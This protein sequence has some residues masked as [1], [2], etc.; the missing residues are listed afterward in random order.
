MKFILNEFLSV[1]FVL[2]LIASLFSVASIASVA[3]AVPDVIYVPEDYVTIQA[4][5]NA[6][7]SGDTIIVRDGTYVEN[8]VVA[9][10]LMIRSENGTDYTIIR[11]PSSKGP[12]F[13]VTS[14]YVNISGFTVRDATRGSN[15]G[16]YVE[17]SVGCI[18]SDNSA[19]N[20]YVG[21]Y[22]VSSKNNALINNSAQNNNMGIYLRSSKN[23]TLVNNNAKNGNRGI[24]LSSSKNNT[25]ISNNVSANDYGLY[26]RYSGGNLIYNNYF[27]NQ[28]NAYDNTNNIW[29][30]KKTP[31]INI[32]GGPNLG[33]NYWSDYMGIDYDGDGLG[34]TL[35]PHSS[36]GGMVNGGDF[37]PLVKVSEPPAITSWSPDS[38]IVNDVEGAKRTFGITLDQVA[39]VRWLVDGTQIGPINESVEEAAF[40][41]TSTEIGIKNVSAIVSNVNGVGMH[42]WAWNITE[43]TVQPVISK[44]TPP[45]NS[46]VNNN[47]TIIGANYSDG[48]G[49]NELLVTLYVDKKDVT[50]DAN[51]TSSYVAY[52]PMD[53]LEDGP[54]NATLN[55]VDSSSNQNYNTTAWNFSVDTILPQTRITSAP[56]QTINHND[57]VFKWTGSD[58]TTPTSKLLYSYKLGNSWSDWTTDEE[59]SFN[60]LSNSDYTFKVKAKDLAGNED[61]TPAEVSFKVS[62]SSSSSFA[63]GGGG[64]GG[65]IHPSQIKTNSRGKVLFTYTE[66]SPDSKAKIIIQKGTIAVDTN[67]NPLT[68]IDIIPMKLGG[69]VLAAYDLRPN[70]ASFDPKMEL[71]IGYNSSE[72]KDKDLIIKSYRDGKWVYLK[73]TVDT[74]KH[75][76]TTKIPHF[77]VFALFAETKATTPESNITPTPV[78]T[79]EEQSSSTPKAEKQPLKLTWSLIFIAIFVIAIIAG[80]VTYILERKRN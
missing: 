60:D 9:K 51:I 58:D 48:S 77:T 39:N 59:K 23:N 12:V 33:G 3:M 75:T 76:A 14:D 26:I 8:I 69:N 52:A 19:V 71:I 78:S 56:P 72:A 28:K 50:S 42:T 30:I 13:K 54:H 47:I 22:L 15:S 18:I 35:L 74:S 46:Y 17:S 80:L 66:E 4:A 43:D 24:Y 34:S 29:N 1:S 41:I 53:P 25:I 44:L 21:I 45:D 65:R 61:K 10:A 2:I 40:T 6:A 70:G 73:T 64:G 27:S 5:V 16:I 57:I 38:E 68:D 63:G 36:S 20:N 79:P 31:R 7:T 49:I 55:V 67:K 32:I 11:A 37:A 62:V